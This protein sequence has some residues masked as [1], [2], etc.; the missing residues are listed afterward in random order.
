NSSGIFYFSLQIGS[1]DDH[2][3]FQHPKI[4]KRSAIPSDGHHSLLTE[5]K[6]RDDDLNMNVIEAWDL[7]YTGKNIVV[8]ILDDGL[9]TDHPDLVDNYDREASTDINDN[10]SDPKPRFTYSNENKHGTRCAGEVAMK[11]NNDVCGVGVAYDSKIGGIRMLDGVVTDAVEAASLSF[12]KQHIDIYSASWGPDDD[13]RTVDGPGNLAKKA[14]K[15]GVT[16]GRGGKGNIFVWASGN[17]GHNSDN[18]NCDGYQDSIY[19]MSISSVDEFGNIPWYL[20]QCSSTLATTYSSGEQGGSQISSTDLQHECT[21]SHTGTSASAPL[22]AGLIALVLEANSALTWRDVQHIVVMT[23]RRGNLI[24]KDPGWVTNGAGYEAGMA[25]DDGCWRHVRLAEKWKEVPTQ[26]ECET[27]VDTIAKKISGSGKIIVTMTTDFC[28]TQTEKVNYLE[29]VQ[30]KMFLDF[31]R[32]GDLSIDLISP[33]GTRSNLL[34]PR[35]YDH[36]ENAF[37][38]WIAM[39]THFWGEKAQGT[40]TLEIQ[41][42]GSSFNT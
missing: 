5:P 38:N 16:E 20:E 29:H 27:P 17:G 32:D 11:A 24:D 30:V 42:K 13:G 37:E 28:D 1:L 40:W 25:L 41:N 2:Y 15:D 34:S 12:N 8:S 21:D 39:T 10:D 23:S 19:T 18:C 22:A 4:S 33:A 14:F 3:L 35:K 31:S 7:G 6:N 26:N 36:S 9:E